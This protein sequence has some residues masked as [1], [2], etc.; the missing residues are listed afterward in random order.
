MILTIRGA[1]QFVNI[2]VALPPKLVHHTDMANAIQLSD[3]GPTCSGWYEENPGKHWDLYVN[4]SQ[5]ASITYLGAG[6][7]VWKRDEI[8]PIVCSTLLAA[9]HIAEKIGVAA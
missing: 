5:V 4:G 3:I 9:Q 6:Y 1:Q 2:F 8:N 7:K